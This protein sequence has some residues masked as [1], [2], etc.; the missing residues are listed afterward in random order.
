MG[1]STV[2]DHYNLPQFADGDKPTWRGDINGAFQI[3]D[4]ALHDK[5]DKATLDYYVAD[6]GGVG[7]G[8]TDD[9]THIQDAI[10]DA[11]AHG[12]GIVHLMRGATHLINGEVFVKDNVLLEGDVANYN[13][14]VGAANTPSIKFGTAN[15]RIRVGAFP[16]NHGSTN[17]DNPQG[18]KNMFIDCN[19]HGPTAI[20]DGAVYFQGTGI[21]VEAVHIINAAGAGTYFDATQNSQFT[22]MDVLKCGM[23]VVLDNGAGGLTFTRC[24]IADNKTNLLST[25]NQSMANAYPY[26]PA[27]CKFEHCIFENYTQIDIE[28]DIQA[29]AIQFSDCGFSNNVTTA[30]PTTGTLIRIA[31]TIYPTVATEGIFDS[32]VFVSEA[33]ESILTLK[34]SNKAYL[35]GKTYLQGSFNAAVVTTAFVQDTGAGSVSLDGQ[36]YQLQIDHLGAAVN[37][38]ALF[39]W[40][41]ERAGTTSY[42][43]DTNVTS[44]ALFVKIVGD[45]GIRAAIAADGSYNWYD[46]SN[47]TQRASISLTAALKTLYYN[48][49]G[50]IMQGPVEFDNT[51]QFDDAV[52]AEANLT[53]DGVATLNGNV[54][55]GGSSHPTHVHGDMTVD[56][57]TVHAGTVTNTGQ[58]TQNGGTVQNGLIE[59]NAGRTEAYASVY[60]P[61][62]GGPIAA[63]ARTTSHILIVLTGTAQNTSFAVANMVSGQRFR[64]TYSVV[65]NAPRNVYWPAGAVPGPSKTLPASFAATGVYSI[66]FVYIGTVWYEIG[67]NF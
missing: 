6:Y 18:I 32:C 36:V 28:V 35:Y 59:V 63:D 54:D 23:G 64:V 44:F 66:D 20:N 12:G 27:H 51:V 24:E 40:A 25:D 21:D 7:D 30:Q 4:E 13:G 67:R 48:P 31:N 57:N 17:G 11:K 38:G 37:G 50:H 41:V 39:N 58:V 47:F 43:V 22:G 49:T 33:G 42:V 52:H 61:V 26:G 53:V 34:G 19:G 3:I 55:M 10:D 9:N 16:G 5:A 2:T 1:S 29:G 15:S 14:Q 45:A 46:G 8:I 56:G 60:G 65:D 62:G